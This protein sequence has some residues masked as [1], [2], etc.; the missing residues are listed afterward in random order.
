MPEVQT[1]RE[2]VLGG[3]VLSVAKA[4]EW[5]RAHEVEPGDYNT[6]LPKDLRFRK[7]QKS[8]GLK[9]TPEVLK[10]VGAVRVLIGDRWQWEQ[11]QAVRFVLCGTPPEI[12]PVGV[13][14][15]VN[16]HPEHDRITLEIARGA[17]VEEVISAFRRAR[18]M[19]DKQGG[20]FARFRSRQATQKTLELA[21]YVAKTPALKWKDRM[22]KWNAEFPKWSYGDGKNSVSRFAQDG[23]A[24]YK[25]VTGRS[26]PQR[27]ARREA[28]M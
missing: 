5:L 21:V 18:R 16:W 28:T 15:S 20:H 7:G 17:T 9:L 3:Q 8:V 11:G 26:W 23:N 10:L 27:K 4:R 19:A 22:V 12:A 13:A 6:S 1:F 24:A 2:E 25:Y 14:V